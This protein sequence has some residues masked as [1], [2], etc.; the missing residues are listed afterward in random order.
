MTRPPRASPRG[1]SA[2]HA[3][4]A[5][6]CPELLA[7][8]RILAFRSALR[9]ARECGGGDVERW[10]VSPPGFSVVAN[11]RGHANAVLDKVSAALA[12]AVAG[13]ASILDRQL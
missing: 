3:A 8:S 12:S 7:A 13:E 6:S 9:T 1:L 4:L 10:Q 5:E 11:D 2:A